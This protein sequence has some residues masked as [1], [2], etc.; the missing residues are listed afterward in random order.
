MLPWGYPNS[1]TSVPGSWGVKVAAIFFQNLLIIAFLLHTVFLEQINQTLP[2]Y[3]MFWLRGMFPWCFL[4]ESCIGTNP[5]SPCALMNALCYLCRWLYTVSPRFEHVWL[6]LNIFFILSKTQ[7]LSNTI[8]VLTC[9][10]PNTSVANQN[11]VDIMH[12]TCYIVLL[13]SIIHQWFEE[14]TCELYLQCNVLNR[15]RDSGW[16]MFSFAFLFSF[17]VVA[18]SP[19]IFVSHIRS[20]C[21]NLLCGLSYESTGIFHYYNQQWRSLF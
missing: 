6:S 20:I 17:S 12:I 11:G 4:S 3:P 9:I 10:L 13:A 1:S 18:W 21:L 5:L 16:L 2:I 19:G 14:S 8:R 7:N 15:L